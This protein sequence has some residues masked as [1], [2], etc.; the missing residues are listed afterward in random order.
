MKSIRHFAFLFEKVLPLLNNLLNVW[1][2]GNDHPIPRIALQSLL[3]HSMVLRILL[4][5]APVI[6]RKIFPVVMGLD[7][8]PVVMNSANLKINAE[9][10]YKLE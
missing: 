8:E 2:G 9:K 7:V 10:K 3:N 5:N 4:E 6:S 1:V